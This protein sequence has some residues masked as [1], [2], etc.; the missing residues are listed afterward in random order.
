MVYFIGS[1]KSNRVKIGYSRDDDTLQVRLKTL[2]NMNVDDIKILKVIDGDQTTERAL[3]RKHQASRIHG[4]I[5]LMTQSL[6][7]DIESDD[8]K[9]LQIWVNYIETEKELR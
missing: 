3:H 2:K 7:D 8:I 6:L 9:D 4:E 5:F 1:D